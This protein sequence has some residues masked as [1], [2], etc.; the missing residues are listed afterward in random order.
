VLKISV[1]DVHELIRI[2]ALLTVG[3]LYLLF[4]YRKHTTT[5]NILSSRTATGRRSRCWSHSSTTFGTTERIAERCTVNRSV[6]ASPS[7][8]SLTITWAIVP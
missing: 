7:R 8:S 2:E 3:L 4:M 1:Y 6:N 5:S